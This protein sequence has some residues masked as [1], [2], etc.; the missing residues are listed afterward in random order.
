MDPSEHML[1]RN[2][3]QEVESETDQARVK[4]RESNDVESLPLVYGMNGTVEEIGKLSRCFNKLVLA[5]H[6]DI[7][8]Q[9]RAEAH[10]RIVTS[11]SMLERLEIAM[12]GGAR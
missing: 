2:L 1:L 11:I 3:Q 6:P 9:W 10:H 5:E 4:I 8:N 7:I 12:R